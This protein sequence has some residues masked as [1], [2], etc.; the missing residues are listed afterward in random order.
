MQQNDDVGETCMGRT[1]SR[2]RLAATLSLSEDFI[3]VHIVANKKGIIEHFYRLWVS[4]LESEIAEM[5]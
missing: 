5:D 2:H 1:C 4:F 3:C